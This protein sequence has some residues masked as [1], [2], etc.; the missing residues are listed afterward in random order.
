M[1][2]AKKTERLRTPQDLI[3]AVN[4]EFGDGTLMLA[5]D[6]RLEITRQSTGHLAVDFALGGGVPRG[7]TVEIYGP[8]AAGK[9]YLASCIVAAAQREGHTAAWLDGEGVFDPNFAAS[10]GVDLDELLYHRQKGGEQL[11]NVMEMLL[12]SGLIAVTVTDSIAS[13]L[14][15]AER[16]NAMGSGSMGMHQAK[17]MSEAMRR[18]TTA[19]QHNTCMLWINQMR[20]NTKSMFGGSVTSGGRAMGFYASTRIELVKTE[21]LKRKKKGVNPKTGGDS[22]DDNVWGHRVLMKV[23]KEKSGGTTPGTT[24]PFVFNYEKGGIDRTEDLIY[25]GQMLGFVHGSPGAQARWW[26]DGHEDDVQVGRTRFKKWLERNDEVC[27]DL[28]LWIV[29]RMDP[30]EEEETDLYIDDDAD[31]LEEDDE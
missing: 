22:A 28:E 4:K 30:G 8:Y 26:V 10:A 3:K 29:N 31:G 16:E 9:T 14:P 6:E 27:E 21:T 7:R 13:L 15:K 18:L 11:V 19:N 1:P 2:K 24:M 5:S 17:M 23:T 20:D 12:R 25:L